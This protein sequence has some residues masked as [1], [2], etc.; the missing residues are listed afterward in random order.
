M[1]LIILGNPA[2]PKAYLQP[3]NSYTNTTYFSF[4]LLTRP[5]LQEKQINFQAAKN[6]NNMMICQLQKMCLFSNFQSK[7]SND[8]S[9]RKTKL[10]L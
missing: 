9:D 3:P 10:N 4:V 6:L 1:K 5:N 7:E 2:A 8:K